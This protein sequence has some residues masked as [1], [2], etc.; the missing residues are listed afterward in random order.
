[1]GCKVWVE[2]NRERRRRRR[3]KFWEVHSSGDFKFTLQKDTTNFVAELNAKPPAVVDLL[4][5][6]AVLQ[7]LK[8]SAK[9]Q[10]SAGGDALGCL[11][12][13]ILV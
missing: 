13:D 9:R 12:V 2:E 10:S 4:R 8:L 6:T 7:H 1:M 11:A 3:R 5:I